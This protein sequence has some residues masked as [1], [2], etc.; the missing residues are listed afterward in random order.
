MHMTATGPATLFLVLVA[1]VAVGAI[2]ATAEEVANATVVEGTIVA[3]DAGYGN[4]QTDVPAS[5][6]T[7]EFGDT[8]T[9]SCKDVSFPAT[10]VSWYEDVGEGEWLGL[11]G[12]GDQVQI[13]VS[14]GDADE[15]SGCAAGDRV[16]LR[17]PAATD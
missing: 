2:E 3:V 15:A 4:L 11:P 9:F 6:M 14:F 1:I 17:L 7:I 16:A 10:W 13:A 12:Q 5:A 8:F